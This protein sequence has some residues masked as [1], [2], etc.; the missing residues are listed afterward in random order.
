MFTLN[1]VT[2]YAI[3]ASFIQWIINYKTD[4][5]FGY[6][7]KHGAYQP[8]II[9]GPTTLPPPPITD[10]TGPSTVAP[11]S[12]SGRAPS[13]APESSRAGAR[14]GKKQNVLV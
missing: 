1:H 3:Y 8:H 5:E 11:T 9:Q 7:G 6:D 14:R 13:A 12:P 2:M 4:M 10:P